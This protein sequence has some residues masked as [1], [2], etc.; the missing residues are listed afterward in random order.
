MRRSLLYVPKEPALTL[1]TEAEIDAA[2]RSLM[3]TQ[4]AIKNGKY[5]PEG[6]W[7][8]RA[9]TKFRL[10]Y[11]TQHSSNALLAVRFPVEF[12]NDFMP[13]SLELKSEKDVAILGLS[14]HL[15]LQQEQRI[16]VRKKPPTANATNN[17][18]ELVECAPDY[19]PAL[20]TLAALH[21]PAAIESSNA[22][23][24]SLGND[25]S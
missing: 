9:E 3:H 23:A 11:L 13:R 5:T 25:R 1:N 14:A 17:I 24:G 8:V 20:A 22:T 6:G 7:L 21:Q 15:L 2:H 4:K 16:K 19:L 18:V 10:G 12:D